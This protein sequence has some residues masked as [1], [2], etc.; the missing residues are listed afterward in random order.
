MAISAE[1]LERLRRLIADGREHAFYLWGPWRR[2]RRE[3]LDM[4]RHECQFCRA[5]G[6]YSRAEIVHHIKH[7][8]ER[9]DLALSIWDPETGERQLAAVCRA[10]HE[11]EHP[12][13]M[14]HLP[15]RSERFETPERWD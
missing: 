2:L 15:R 14:V 9:P 5:R 1:R 6:R 10:C 8:R 4:D 12:E 13:A 7:L 3:V 11:M